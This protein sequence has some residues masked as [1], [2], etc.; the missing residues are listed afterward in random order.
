MTRRDRV[1]GA[2]LLVGVIAIGA[3]W[4]ANRPPVVPAELV[5]TALGRTVVTDDQEPQC[6]DRAQLGGGWADLC[7]VVD[8]IPDGSANTQDNY[9]LRVYGSFQGLRW[10]VARADLVGDPDG[11]A[12][13]IWPKFPIEGACHDVNVHLG[14]SIGVEPTESVCGR[15]E[16]K[17]ELVSWIQT[18]T[19]TCE[20]CL[21]PDGSTKPLAMYAQVAVD[22]GT[23]PA[24]DVSVAGGY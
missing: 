5:G 2:L 8:R 15:T 1:L 13:M 19:W 16:G 4:I 3:A 9:R 6:A 21:V 12:Y 23:V 22:A 17:L 20:L 18:V 24:W 7:W 11:G 14:P 10:L